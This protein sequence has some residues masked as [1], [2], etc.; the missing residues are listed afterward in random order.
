LRA[1]PAVKAG[2]PGG[3]PVRNLV[4]PIEDRPGMVANSSRLNSRG[5]A[6][7][8]AAAARAIAQISSMVGGPPASA[9]AAAA[10]ADRGLYS[11]K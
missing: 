11:A 6:A 4:K 9:R 7:C 3:R 5:R 8:S 2:P 10:F 1:H